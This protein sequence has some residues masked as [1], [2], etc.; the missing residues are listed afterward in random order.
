[1][2]S[3]CSTVDRRLIKSVYCSSLKAFLTFGRWSAARIMDDWVPRRFVRSV[4]PYGFVSVLLG[5][6]KV[7]IVCLFFMNV[8][9]NKYQREEDTD[10]KERKKKR[11]QRF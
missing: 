7:A 2:V 9:G 6:G 11:K 5:G 10:E 4:L 1:M 3:S 8:L